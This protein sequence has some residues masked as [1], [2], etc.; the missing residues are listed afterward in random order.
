MLVSELLDIFWLTSHPSYGTLAFTDASDL[1]KNTEQT[2]CELCFSRLLLPESNPQC[3]IIPIGTPDAPVRFGQQG[4]IS[5][6]VVEKGACIRGSIR[7]LSEVNTSV[8]DIMY[9]GRERSGCVLN[10]PLRLDS[11]RFKTS[12]AAMNLIAVCSRCLLQKIQT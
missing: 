4:C 5:K 8:Q 10:L 3:V 6:T 11:F 7:G 2:L 9:I 1:P 12:A